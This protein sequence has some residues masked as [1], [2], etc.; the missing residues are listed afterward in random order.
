MLY[1][2]LRPL[3]FSQDAETAHDRI[4]RFGRALQKNAIAR[5]ILSSV[6]KYTH[7]S[8]HTSVFDINFPNPVGVA[9]GFD[10]P[11]E[12]VDLMEAIGFGF[13]EIGAVTPRP[14]FGNEKPR[15][16]R[17]PQDEA[18]INRMGFNNDGVDVALE[19]LSKRVSSIVVG[20][21]IGKNKDTPNEQ[22][23]DDYLRLFDLLQEHVDF[24]TVNV[25]SP[26]TANL[27]KLQEKGPLMELLREL[28]ERN[29][30]LP[31]PKKLLLKISP[32][33]TAMQMEDLIDVA[34]ETGIDGIIATNTTVSRENLRT[35]QGKVIDIGNGGLSG[36]PLR[37]RA[38]EVISYIYARTQGALPIIG[39][40]GISSDEH[41]YEKIRAGASLVQ[42]YSGLI[43]KGP[44]L[45]KQINKGLVQLL[46][47]DGF[48]NIQEAVGANHK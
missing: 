5:R 33:M 34:L 45:V 30:Q 36:E 3:L 44:G 48:S 31:K 10:K 4:H 9:A 29:T 16:F 15:L 19:N 23:A 14:Q 17:L 22:A 39:V 24:L 46:N 38:T 8:L 6:Y 41:A 42:V 18:I 28:Q 47:K 27:R 20:A 35:E 7:P 43:Y 21:N 40:G 1:H 13:T 11:A 37:E 26:N 12:L 2:L 32:D 25:S